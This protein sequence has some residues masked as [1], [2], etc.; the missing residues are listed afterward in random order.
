MTVYL[1][2]LE[3]RFDYITAVSWYAV[4]NVQLL[5]FILVVCIFYSELLVVVFVIMSIFYPVQFH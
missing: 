1:A 5:L 2:F 4:S 3:Y